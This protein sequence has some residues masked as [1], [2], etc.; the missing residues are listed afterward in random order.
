MPDPGALRELHSGQAKLDASSESFVF[1][2]LA[3]DLVESLKG[4]GK[5]FD[6]HP[7]DPFSQAISPAGSP[8][9]SARAVGPLPLASAA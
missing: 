4:A 3:A 6:V 9:D 1:M 8:R 2:V 5:R 7:S